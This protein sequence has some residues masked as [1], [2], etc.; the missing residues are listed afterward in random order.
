MKVRSFLKTLVLTGLLIVCSISFCV[1]A[2]ALTDKAE[3]PEITR[4]V[5]GA[6]LSTEGLY[7]SDTWA[8]DST[9]VSSY[10]YVLINQEGTEEMRVKNYPGDISTGNSITVGKYKVTFSL[11]VPEEITNEVVITLENDFS[12]YSVAFNEGNSFS[13][14][15]NFYPGEYTVKSI[16]ATGSDVAYTLS[17]EFILSVDDE[18]KTVPLALVEDTSAAANGGAQEGGM[19]GIVKAVDSNGDLLWDTIKLLIA[20][21]ILF[22]IYLLIQRKRK[23]AEEIRR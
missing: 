11:A 4:W 20:C 2:S 13:A 21:G 7:L 10:E 5:N 15:D 18:G 22:V 1:P 17:R 6:A 23:K 19:L 14:S 8:L 16:E 12:E 9:G 3:L